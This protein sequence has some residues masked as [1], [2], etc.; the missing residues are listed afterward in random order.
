MRW[1]R[2]TAVGIGVSGVP[3]LVPGPP[4]PLRGLGH[5]VIALPAHRL[6]RR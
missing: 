5:R 3:L 1:P 2:S 6:G 4:P